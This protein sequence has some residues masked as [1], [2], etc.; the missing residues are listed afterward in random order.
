MTS[1]RRR[2]RT[3]AIRSVLAF[4]FRHW[5][6]Q[7]ALVSTIALSMTGATLADIFIPLYAGHLID[8]LASAAADREAALD[9]AIRALAAMTGLGVLMLVLRH[10]A[11]TGI[12]PFTLRIMSAVGHD[13]FHRVQRFSSDWHA[14]TFAGSTVRK[15]TRGMW[16][17]DT[18]HDTLLLALLPSAV[19]LFGTMI[20]LALHWPVMGALMGVGSVA[21]IALTVVLSTRYIAP[22][23]RLSNSWDTRIGGTIADAISCNAVVKSF[24]AEAREDARLAGVIAKWKRRTSRTWSRHTWSATGQIFVLLVLRLGV[25]ALAIWLWWQGRATP[26]DV[27][28]VLTTY[29]VVNGYLRDVGMHINHLQRSVNEMEELVDLH[30]E[31]LGVEDRPTPRPFASAPGRSGSK[32]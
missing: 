28:Y 10:I 22:A 20:L 26:G 11:W 29:F 17:L 5:R 18:L 4:T 24:G 19:V 15:I 31:A 2:A 7:P 32:T 14:N 16:S 1:P 12:I 3:D 30:D 6:K 25:T 23:S 27:T 21:Y 13:A 9:A 8:A